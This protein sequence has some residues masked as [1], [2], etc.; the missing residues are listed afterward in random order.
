MAEGPEAAFDVLAEALGAPTLSPEERAAVLRLAKV[1]SALSQDM[2]RSPTIA[3]M[4]AAA[5]ASEEEVLEA[6]EAGH[7]YRFA[8][9]DAPAATDDEGTQSLA[10]QLGEEDPALI[11]SEHRA[12]LSPL[13][14]RLPQRERLILHYRFFEGKTQSEIAAIIGISQMHVSRLLA[15]SLSQLRE[16]AEDADGEAAS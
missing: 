10:S 8:S 3:E 2:G 11:E 14:E 7:A 12:A 5:E 6:I 4:A 13:V 9:L 15:R 1:V 16:W